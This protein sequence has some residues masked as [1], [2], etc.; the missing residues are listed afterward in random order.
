MFCSQVQDETQAQILVNQNLSYS[1]NITDKSTNNKA[2]IEALV[3][4]PANTNYFCTVQD[5]D[6]G[7][8]SPGNRHCCCKTFEVNSNIQMNEEGGSDDE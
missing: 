7:D 3:N 8:T 5:I 6:F 4:D 2:A 1:Y